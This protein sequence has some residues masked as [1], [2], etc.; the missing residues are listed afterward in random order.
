M[1]L[2]TPPKN[3]VAQ[4]DRR[5]FELIENLLALPAAPPDWREHARERNEGLP[6]SERDWFEGPPPNDAA[7]DILTEYWAYRCKWACYDA[8]PPDPPRAVR[9]QLLS[10]VLSDKDACLPPGLLDCLPAEPDTY[11]E[12]GRIV[13]DHEERSGK[14]GHESEPGRW[15]M[16]TTSYFRTELV[17]AVSETSFRR[18]AHEE[19]LRALATLDWAT[20][21]PLLL[22]HAAGEDS[23]LAALANAILYEHAVEAVEGEATSVLRVT[24]KSIV[25]DPGQAG[26]ARNCAFDAL[27]LDEWS[28]RDEWFLSL[29]A[30]ETIFAL[31]EESSI[32]VALRRPVRADPDKWIPRII[33]LVGHPDRNVHNAAVLCLMEFSVDSGHCRED[34]L[35]PLLPFLTDPNWARAPYWPYQLRLTQTMASVDLPQSVPHLL[36]LAER[37]TEHELEAAATA[38]AHYG[39]LEGI[40]LLKQALEREEGEYHRRKIIRAIYDLLTFD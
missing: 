10:D 30:D 21:E 9:R 22:G 18:V 14:P 37:A 35:V 24:L 16:L 3:V 8:E 6:N 25:E 11:A 38:L 20:A 32:Y 5:S 36:M 2:V 27:F 17:E 33:P 28:G 19:E 15:L 39:A 4:A 23:R 7:I 12:I 34:A 26:F 40:A 31:H 1:A 13:A 29:F